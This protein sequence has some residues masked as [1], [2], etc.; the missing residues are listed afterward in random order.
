MKGSNSKTP[1]SKTAKPSP[2]HPGSK[3]A[4]PGQS[5]PGGK[6]AKGKK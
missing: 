5:A 3:T 4:Q 1:P 6:G 2:S